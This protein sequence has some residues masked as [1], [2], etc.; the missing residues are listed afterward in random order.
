MSIE[1][2]VL[3]TLKGSGEPL[4]AGEVAEKLGLESKE[5]TKAVQSLKKQGLIESPKRCFYQAVK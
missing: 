2:Q 3:D 5:V 1:N 4:K